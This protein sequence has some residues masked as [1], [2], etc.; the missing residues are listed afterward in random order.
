[1]PNERWAELHSVS[2]VL[3]RCA[4]LT[5]TRLIFR[6]ALLET[7]QLVATR[8]RE[9]ELAPCWPAFG[10]D[11]RSS[12]SLMV[13]GRATNGFVPHFLPS[14][15]LEQATREDVMRRARKFAESPDDCEPLYWIDRNDY[16]KQGGTI[17]SRSSFWRVS[18]HFLRAVS[19]ADVAES[20]H[21]WRGIGWSN[22]AKFAPAARGNPSWRLRQLHQRS[23]MELLH[24]EVQEAQPAVVLVI[25]GEDWYAPCFGLVT[26]IWSPSSTKFVKHVGADG[27]RLWFFTERPERRPENEFVLELT[28]ALRRAREQPA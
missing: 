12:T 11:Y 15:L 3:V 4:F 19:G 28:A 21:W 13:V 7:T 18:R 27:N 1:M 10:A 16:A 26:R 5:T 6:E 17:G 20:Q 22:L 25:A 14:Q 8:E 24:R 2:T 23:A 9:R